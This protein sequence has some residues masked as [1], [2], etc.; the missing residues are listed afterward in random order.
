MKKI[1]L[2]LVVLSTIFMV[3]CTNDADIAS[4][5]LVYAA[6]NFEIDR[7]IVFVNGITDNYLLEIEGKC[8]IKADT[9]DGQLEVVCKTDT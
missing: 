4:R 6:D 2:M 8:S 3:G 1:L 5:N 7:R 9:Y